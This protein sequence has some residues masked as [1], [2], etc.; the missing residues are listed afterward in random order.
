MM[1][2]NFSPRPRI[3][4]RRLIMV[5]EGSDCVG[6]LVVTSRVKIT[7]G[8]GSVRFVRLASVR[9]AGRF[10]STSGSFR[11]IACWLSGEVSNCNLCALNSADARVDGLN[12]PICETCNL[13]VH[14][15]TLHVLNSR[16]LVRPT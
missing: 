2:M 13:Y 14:H 12:H 8:F 7:L 10:V 4:G 11:K 15:Q 5:N 6:R 16:N 1:R 3:L 9:F